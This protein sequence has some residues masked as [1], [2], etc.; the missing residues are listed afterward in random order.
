MDRQLAGL[1]ILMTTWVV[2][3]MIIMWSFYSD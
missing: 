2:V 1:S 3:V